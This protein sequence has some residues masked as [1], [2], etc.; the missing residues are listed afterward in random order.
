MD[1]GNVVIVAESVTD[2]DKMISLKKGFLT[3]KWLSIKGTM[4]IIPKVAKAE[5]WK[6]T[7]NMAKGQNIDIIMIAVPKEF[8]E[9]LSLFTSG[10]KAIKKNISPALII[11][12]VKPHIETINAMAI[13]DIINRTYEL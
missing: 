11:E 2:N 12:S 10:A 9:S 7:F 1:I 3:V 8:I 4:Y 6:P 13:K 5:S